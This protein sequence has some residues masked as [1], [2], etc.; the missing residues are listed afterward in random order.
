MDDKEFLELVARN[1]S[2]IVSMIK[3]LPMLLGRPT[4]WWTA[5]AFSITTFW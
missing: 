5:R 2:A 4:G 3:P 1:R